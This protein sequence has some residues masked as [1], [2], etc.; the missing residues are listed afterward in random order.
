MKFLLV[1]DRE[2]NLLALEVLIEREDVQIFTA[3]SGKAALKLSAEH[4][5]ALAIVHVHLPDM[6]GFELT[7]LM[8]GKNCSKDVSIIFVTGGGAMRTSSKGRS[9][10]A[11]Q[12]FFWSQLTHKY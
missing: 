3:M 1:H 8:R 9:T 2:A 10:S 4:E 6:S 11:P 12:T 5:F 7:E